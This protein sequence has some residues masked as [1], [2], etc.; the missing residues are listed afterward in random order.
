MTTVLF[1]GVP[2]SDLAAAAPWHEAFHGREP[3]MRPH[4]REV[5]WQVDETGWVYVVEDAERAGRGLLTIIVT[6]LDER[7]EQLA[8]RGLVPAETEMTSPR[9]VTFEDPDGNRLSLAQI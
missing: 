7:L 9:K 5:C 2:V 1:A 8:A 4:D 3:E 6:D